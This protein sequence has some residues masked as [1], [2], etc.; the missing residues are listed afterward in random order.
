MTP[1]QAIKKFKGVAK[2]ARALGKTRQTIYNWQKQGDQ[3][4]EAFEALADKRLEELKRD[5]SK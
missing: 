1:T 4:P 3:F 5:G 2:L